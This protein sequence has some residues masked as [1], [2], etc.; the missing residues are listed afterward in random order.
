M[1][2]GMPTAP[3]VSLGVGQGR[4]SAAILLANSQNPTPTAIGADTPS[5]LG[6]VIYMLP[7][8]RALH[9]L[10]TSEGGNH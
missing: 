2:Q 6:S 10:L 8:A 1:G 9:D 4:A 5:A 3:A 7:I